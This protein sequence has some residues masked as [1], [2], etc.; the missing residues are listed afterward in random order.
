MCVQVEL[1]KDT[2]AA[3]CALTGVILQA[4]LATMPELQIRKAASLAI[5]DQ[6]FQALMDLLHSKWSEDEDD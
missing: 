1:Q 4:R 5:V 6:D 3:V 2:M